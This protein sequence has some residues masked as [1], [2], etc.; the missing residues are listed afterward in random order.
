MP[1]KKHTQCEVEGWHHTH[2]GMR[3]GGLSLRLPGEE[4]TPSL[5][6]DGHYVHPEVRGHNSS[7]KSIAKRSGHHGWA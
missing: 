1:G 4:D 3:P 5:E 7:A 2:Q 6:R